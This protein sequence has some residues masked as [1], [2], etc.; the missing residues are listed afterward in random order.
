[1]TIRTVEVVSQT[2]RVVWEN[3]GS[4]GRR[5]AAAPARRGA[6]SPPVRRRVPPVGR[7]RVG[8]ARAAPVSEGRH[9]M[10]GQQ[11]V[12]KQIQMQLLTNL[13]WMVKQI[14]V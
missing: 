8:T 2:E 6:R 5:A 7:R 9:D 13:N 11:G 12:R 4:L 3:T 10:T 1:M 14:L